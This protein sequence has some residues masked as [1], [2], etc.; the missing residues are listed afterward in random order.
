MGH[1]S[2]E[3]TSWN[4]FGSA[5][6]KPITD[7]PSN[8]DYLA[9]VLPPNHN[10]TADLIIDKHTLLP[11]YGPFIPPER[12]RQLR[13][14]MRGNRGGS[15]HGRLGIL[16]TNISLDFL[17]YCPSCVE[18]DKKKFRETYWH[19]LHQVPGVKVCPTHKIFLKDSSIHIRNR[20]NHDAYITAEQ[21]VTSDL[22]D[23][24]D[25]TNCAHQAYLRIAEEAFWLLKQGCLTSDLKAHRHRYIGLLFEKGFSTYSGTVRPSKLV[26]ALHEF[27]S[28]EFLASLGCS[29]EGKYNW[30]VR[31][32]QNTGRMQ[33]PLY[34]LLLMQFLG[35]TVKD[36][37]QLLV[38]QQPFGEGPWP[39]LNRGSDHFRQ[40][41]IAQCETTFLYQFPRRPK[42]I[43]RCSCGFVYYRVGPDRSAEDRFKMNSFLSLGYVWKDTLKKLYKKKT[44]SSKKLSEA[45]GVSPATIEKQIT[46]LRLSIRRGSQKE[47]NKSDSIGR[48][49]CS[50]KKEID[51]KLRKTNRNSWAKA[52]KEDP[53]AGRC[54]IRKKLPT[55]FNWLYKHDK[56]WLNA[57]LP[58]RLSPKGPPGYINWENRDKEIAVAVL[59][60]TERLKCLPGRPVRA[61]FTIVAKNI[62]K[63]WMIGKRKDKLPLTVKTLK[64]VE[65]SVEDYAIRRVK[66]ATELYREEGISTSFSRLYTRAA[67]SAK[68]AKI[69]KVECAI[70]TAILSLEPTSQQNM[71]PR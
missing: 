18:D 43:F 39:C 51:L 19:R 60:E 27:Y 42:G 61:S 10:L 4:L 33:H 14:D 25:P 64:D 66:W 6:A 3:L 36:F 52:I 21:A 20:V 8:L 34:H 2:K 17:R 55:V 5:Q 29:L 59:E 15:I 47:I 70:Q 23:R 16:T 40:N 45:L 53:E 62:G 24:L 68:I 69:P 26:D 11:F 41:L 48:K 44:H 7:L 57:H 50:P 32:I 54:A 13:T 28:K 31:L 38:K 49:H 12:L 35:C 56:E 37:F 71:P 63:L 58:A 46:K 22:A 30:L 65:E 9:S 67:V 1:P